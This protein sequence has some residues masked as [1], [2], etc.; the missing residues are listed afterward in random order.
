MEKNSKKAGKTNT[1]VKVM[2]GVTATLVILLGVMIFLYFDLRKM[3]SSGNDA[4]VDQITET[5]ETKTDEAESTVSVG[6]PADAAKEEAYLKALDYLEKGDAAKAKTAFYAVSGYKDAADYCKRLNNYIEYTDCLDKLEFDAAIDMLKESRGILD[7][8]DRIADIELL[9]MAD[10]DISLGEFDKVK[11]ADLYSNLKALTPDEARFCLLTS[12]ARQMMY[13][14][15]FKEKKAV[16]KLMAEIG[17]NV[18]WLK[19]LGD[20]GEHRIYGK[21]T[22]GSYY[23]APDDPAYSSM[24]FGPLFDYEGYFDIFYR[25]EKETDYFYSLIFGY[26]DENNKQR[27]VTG[28]FEKD[29]KVKDW[30]VQ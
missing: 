30:F 18:D 15:R 16:G 20:G 26:V 21:S 13:L 10:F 19:T 2:I 22:D 6:N 17:E 7:S 14:G 11:E 24:G 27:Y 25:D 1:T 28:Y 5:E 8:E 23:G 9:K 4:G 3:N 29:G 12:K